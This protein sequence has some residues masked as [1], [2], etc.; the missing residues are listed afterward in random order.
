VGATSNVDKTISDTLLING[1]RFNVNNAVLGTR[2]LIIGSGSV[3]IFNNGGN[4]P[5]LRVTNNVGTIVLEVQGTIIKHATST[6]EFGPNNAAASVVF[7]N[8]SFYIHRT[9]GTNIPRV[10]TAGT[11][12][13]Q[14][15]STCQI[16]AAATVPTSTAPASIGQ[17]FSNFTWNVTNQTLASFDPYFTAG[18][19]IADKLEVRSTGA[20]GS[21][22]FTLNGVAAL[23]TITI[24]DLVISATG[25]TNFNTTSN[26]SGTCVTNLNITGNFTRTSGTIQSILS[27]GTTTVTLNGSAGDQA[28][29]YT[30]AGA[31]AANSPINFV[32]NK[33]VGATTVTHT[34][35]F[36]YPGNLTG[37]AGTLRTDGTARTV[38]VNG[39]LS[40]AGT[41]DLSTSNAAHVLDLKGVN[42]AI[43]TFTP[44]TGSTVSYTQG[45]AGQNVMALNYNSLTFDNFNKALPGATIGIRGSF[46][47]GSGIHTVTNNTIDFN[48]ASAQTIP[49]LTSA[50]SGGYNNV[51]TSGGGTKSLVASTLISGGL[52]L[53]D[54]VI[55]IGA[56]NLTVTGLISG[57]G[58]TTNMV[59]TNSNG[60]LIKLG[61]LDGHFNTIYPV[62]TGSVY[63]PLVIQNLSSSSLS[64][65]SIAVH[66]VASKNVNRTANNVLNKYWEV[67]TSGITLNS[68]DAE[69]TYA[70]SEFVDGTSGDYVTRYWNGTAWVSPSPFST[71][72]NPFTGSV[73]TNLTG[74]WTSGEPTSLSSQTTYTST[75]LGGDWNTG[76]TWSPTGPPLAADNVIISSGSPVTIS[77][78]T[79]TANNITIL[80]GAIL[81][82]GTTTGHTFNNVAGTGT[83]RLSS[84][85]LPTTSY[86]SFVSSSGGTIEYQGAGYNL[87]A[88]ATYNNLTISGSSTKT[89]ATNILVNGDLTIAS[90]ALDLSGGNPTL[91]L[92]GIFSNSGGYASGTGLHTFTGASKTI[93]STGA[94]SIDN[95]SISG[96][97]TSSASSLSV[98]T[99][100]AGSGSLT[101]SASNT[102]NI[103]SVATLSSLIATA[104]NS[105]VN[106]SQ[107]TPGQNI[108]AGDYFNLTYSNFDK[109][110]PASTITIAGTY[111][112]G[113][114]THSVNG[115]TIDFVGVSGQG[116]PATQYENVTNSN[117]LNRIL[118][119]SGIIK[120]D[121]NFIAGS[122]A[123]TLTGS[124]VEYNSPLA[125]QT[126]A[127]L[128]YNNLTFSGAGGTRTWT[129]TAN[130]VLTGNL[131]ISGSA[132]FTQLGGFNLY[133]TGT[134]TAVSMTGGL[135]TV[136]GANR[137]YC[138]GTFTNTGGT[139]LNTTNF[140]GGLNDT[141]AAGAAN[142]Q[143][144]LASSIYIHNR[145][146]GNLP[147]G[148]WA[149]VSTI[150]VTGIVNTAFTLNPNQRYGIFEWNCPGQTGSVAFNSNGT[151][152]NLAQSFNV[153][154]TGVITAALAFQGGGLGDKSV[155]GNFTVGALGKVSCYTISSGSTSTIRI[156]GDLLNNGVIELGNVNP[157]GGN[158]KWDVLVSGNVTNSGTIQKQYGAYSNSLISMEGAISRVFTQA[159]TMS[160]GFFDVNKS[161]GNVTLGGNVSVPGL[162]LTNGKLLVNG[163]RTLTYTRTNSISQ[164]SGYV[165]LDV[166]AANLFIWAPP[167]S[168]AITT[169]RFPVGPEGTI[170]GIRALSLGNFTTPAGSPTVSIRARNNPGTATNSTS[171]ANTSSVE[172]YIYDVTTNL[173]FPAL[174]VTMSALLGASDFFTSDPVNT[175][176]DIFKAKFVAPLSPW[177]FLGAAPFAGTDGA[178]TTV[179]Q[180]AITLT[181]GLTRLI[182]G[183]SD[184]V[185]LGTPQAISWTGL[186]STDWNDQANWSPSQVPSLANQRLTIPNTVRK[187]VFTGVGLS[188]RAITM[189]LGSSLTI[190]G[191]LTLDSAFTNSGILNC[192]GLFTNSGANYVGPPASTVFNYGGSNGV[193]NFGGWLVT[194][195]STT[196]VVVGSPTQQFNITDSLKL[197]G[198]GKLNLNGASFKLKSTASKTAKI[199]TIP[200][201]ATLSGAT[202]VTWQRYIPSNT[203]GWYFLGTPIQGQF[204]SNWGDN[205][206]IYLPG[207][208]PPLY[209]V[210]VERATVFVYDGTAVPATNPLIASEKNG[211]RIAPAAGPVSVGKGFRA[212]LRSTGFLNG[213]SKTYDNTGTV[214][215]GTF[216]FSPTFVGA[217]FNGGGTNFLANPY[218]AAI[219]WDATTGWTKTNVNNAIYVWNG[220]NNQ[221]MAYV[222]GLG[223]NGG[224]NIIPAGQ[225]F[226]IKTAASPTLTATENVKFSGS[227]TFARVATSNAY[228][229]IKLQNA[230]GLADEN[231]LRVVEGGTAGFDGD[232]DAYKLEGGS[233]SLGMI[234]GEDR[235]S[236][237]TLGQLEAQTIVP[238]MVNGPTGNTNLRFENLDE[239]LAGKMMW[240]K[241]NYLGSITQVNEADVFSFQITAD[242]ASR[243]DNRFE[244]IFSTE[245]VTAVKSSKAGIQLSLFPNPS[246]NGEFTISGNENFNGGNL[247]IYD[248]AGK[249]VYKHSYSKGSML[250]VKTNLASGMYQVNFQTGNGSLNQKLIIN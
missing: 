17:A 87:P 81:T 207:G 24:R 246:I 79:R 212:H 151:N 167:A 117:N 198:T 14:T 149:A 111:S 6:G 173:A 176:I 135:F 150:R 114:G 29:S 60:N 40:G 23:R 100:L 93:S 169:F 227:G 105:T 80:A 145:D 12:T 197:N 71:G 44:G 171:V 243:G 223:T 73:T 208:T 250:K 232:L 83:L 244:L 237:Q 220:Q 82:L 20:S 64:S 112:P 240:V 210:I 126:V 22:I 36:T 130:T 72:A 67:T 25:V 98:P 61:T 180:P 222:G 249:V 144:P 3:C 16:D 77:T 187:P 103:G 242:A 102:L 209:D 56:N 245:D 170:V 216:N 27:S 46:I 99:S 138:K 172:K 31:I 146:G 109:V 134:A 206:E 122:G 219:N 214:T 39:N 224:T 221:Y 143:F 194:N 10:T 28:V 164:T 201:T 165:A 161:A 213:G 113:T 94:L 148:N 189:S 248:V 192:T 19:S 238:L 107:S 33:T 140:L 202:N 152:F 57:T 47:P 54:G 157:T 41:I 96:T 225:A 110:L 115:N 200:A 62:G 241:D 190:N 101:L 63:T 78:N 236:I 75:G 52:T 116:I 69:F 204:L 211:W 215:Q 174:D 247:T 86:T 124:T 118:A 142:F 45:S 84:G 38:T 154:N 139:F 203:Q 26:A 163:G 129:L 156:G 159:G 70:G 42:N 15:G 186:V 32:V 153:I 168:T 175:D 108:I 88:Q 85:S 185:N 91:T 133:S 233:L 66:A 199:G 18:F 119:N 5:L 58:S 229:R 137:F 147:Y 217:G 196:G 226:T 76:G 11:V 55:A 160:S 123:Y 125:G 68:A 49:A 184:N 179:S 2:R 191:N 121:G 43:S 89:L 1:G 13:W 239:L 158:G 166:A 183:K 162:Q 74:E 131:V 155:V 4:S 9:N 97:Y 106:Y 50:S 37:T 193:N 95:L 178:N 136:Q 218:P 228:V 235:L 141:T 104:S 127:N 188:F 21:N 59:A 7:T 230:T 35:N 182:L 195:S 8:G 30:G 65:A 231:V 92:G 90:S 132:N 48:S 181:N 34:S 51:I 177:D 128:A 120:V 234:A 205:F 53:T